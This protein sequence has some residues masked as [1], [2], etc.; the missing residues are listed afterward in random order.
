LAR[1][2]ENLIR[3][4]KGIGDMLTIGKPSV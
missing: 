4:A 2:K 1:T 3:T